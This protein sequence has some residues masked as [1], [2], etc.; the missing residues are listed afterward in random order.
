MT[1]YLD[2][3]Y[4]RDA[5][6][7]LAARPPSHG[8]PEQQLIRAHRRAQ[9]QRRSTAF[10]AVS[11][12]GFGTAFGA[13]QL[14]GDDPASG[15]AL[16]LGATPAASATPQL[17]DCQ[18]RYYHLPS[19]LPPPAPVTTESKPTAARL[20]VGGPSPRPLSTAQRHPHVPSTAADDAIV[21]T[22][23]DGM[24]ALCVDPTIGPQFGSVTGS[25]ILVTTSNGSPTDDANTYQQW[26][27]DLAGPAAR[28]GTQ[29]VTLTSG[30]IVASVSTDK[31]AIAY[32]I[33]PQHVVT[34]SAEVQPDGSRP[35]TAEQLAGWATRVDVTLQG[36][37]AGA[38]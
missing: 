14:A 6:H 30:S 2:D 13:R 18:P 10:V 34:L 33:S 5:L 1:T 26:R 29:T 21:A 9:A 25:V 28:R 37:R 4:L 8:L 31:G 15:G 36:T 23:P 7:R 35:L 16:R 38:G 32:L 24:Q 20:P 3:D 17:P 27:T 12:V 19:P 22:A 11:L